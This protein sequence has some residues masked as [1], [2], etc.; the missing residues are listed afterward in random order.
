MDVAKQL[1]KFPRIIAP[2]SSGLSNPQAFLDYEDEGS[3]I[4]SNVSNYLPFNMA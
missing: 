3:I 1:S 4:L 2:T